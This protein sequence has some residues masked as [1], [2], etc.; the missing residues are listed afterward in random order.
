M[1]VDLKAG[2]VAP[3]QNQLSSDIAYSLIGSDG[4]SVQTSNLSQ[5]PLSGNKVLVRFDVAISNTLSDVILTTP[6]VPTPPAGVTGVVLFPFQ[7]TVTLG[8]S[9]AIN[10]STDWDGA[11]FSFFND[12]NCTGAPNSIAFAGRNTPHR[13]RPARRRQ[14]ELSDSRSTRTSSLSTW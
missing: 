5:T 14:R 6:T 9:S 3:V 2:T 7:A 10:P 4:V 12:I 8:P 11:P 1:H 13:W